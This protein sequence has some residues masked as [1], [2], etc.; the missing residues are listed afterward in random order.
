MV[1]IPGAK[2]TMG[3]SNRSLSPATFDAD[4][5]GPPRI[6]QVSLGWCAPICNALPSAG[7]EL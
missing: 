3:H 5:E 1:Y 7:F 6:V 2:F 4:G